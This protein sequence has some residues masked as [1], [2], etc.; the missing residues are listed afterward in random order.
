MNGYPRFGWVD[1]VR[2][3]QP[4]NKITK[5]PNNKLKN[6]KCHE[7]HGHAPVYLDAGVYLAVG[8]DE[9]V[10]SYGAFVPGGHLGESLDVV[11]AEGR[12]GLG[13]VGM[14]GEE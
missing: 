7:P 1:I 5:Q 11:A 8:G 6:Q 12:E 10:D 2:F 14:G 4:N 3:Q 9:H 13:L